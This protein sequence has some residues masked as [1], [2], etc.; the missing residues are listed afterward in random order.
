MTAEKVKVIGSMSVRPFTL[1]RWLEY[2][3][4]IL[5]ISLDQLPTYWEEIKDLWHD[6]RFNS[7]VQ[8][9]ISVEG[10]EPQQ[11]YHLSAP[12]RR[13]LLFHS[14][15]FVSQA[16]GPGSQMGH[17][18]GQL[19]TDEKVSVAHAF[20]HVFAAAFEILFGTKP[21]KVTTTKELSNGEHAEYLI[22]LLSEWKPCSA[23][24]RQS[25]RDLISQVAK[26][27][28]DYFAGIASD[29]WPE[30]QVSIIDVLLK[31][32]KQSINSG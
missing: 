13:R 27:V 31:L 8:I 16:C 26:I 24:E 3:V 19:K 25:A 22:T 2:I 1:K 23:K 20:D 6:R 7:I 17:F 9:Y 4:Q 32:K 14:Q 29:D 30:R 28:E 18:V 10:D 12:E 21:Y 5:W 11:Y 15:L